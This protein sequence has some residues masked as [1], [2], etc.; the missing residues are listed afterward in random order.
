[1]LRT[2]ARTQLQ[3]PIEPS[4]PWCRDRQRPVF[5]P[6]PKEADQAK[7]NLIQAKEQ[8]KDAAADAKDKAVDAKDKAATKIKSNEPNAMKFFADLAAGGTAGGL[9]K[10]V[11]APIER[12]KLL[13]QTQDSNPRIKSGEIA[14]YTGVCSV[15]SMSKGCC[16]YFQHLSTM[17]YKLLLENECPA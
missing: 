15:R 2:R 13:L 10:T 16:S 9:S 12:V 3:A 14:R 5:I 7:A 4:S 6:A 11:V 8:A 17:H 1:M